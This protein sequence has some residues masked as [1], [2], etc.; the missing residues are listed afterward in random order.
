M[1]SCSL[2]PPAVLTPSIV[3]EFNRS[4]RLVHAL[5]CDVPLGDHGAQYDMQKRFAKVQTG[6]VNPF[7]DR[8]GCTL[9]A[10]IEEAMF[11]AILAEQQRADPLK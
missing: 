2:R 3:D 7:I 8:T 5:P 1:F 11:H 9:E 4:F 6:G 10:D